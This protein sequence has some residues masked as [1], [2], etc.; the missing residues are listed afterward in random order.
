M[1][2]YNPVP[3]PPSP[4]SPTIFFL[5]LLLL[6]LLLFLVFSCSGPKKILLVELCPEPDRVDGYETFWDSFVSTTNLLFDP[7]DLDKVT[8]TLHFGSKACTNQ[9]I[10]ALF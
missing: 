10:R 7:F 6:L 9:A 1:I 5:L 2:T 4:S 3:S 8:T